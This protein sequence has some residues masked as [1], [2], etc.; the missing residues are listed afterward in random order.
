MPQAQTITIDGPSASGKSTVAQQLADRL[1][2]LYFDTGV[3]YRAVTYA[4]LE[5]LGSVADEEKVTTLTEKIAIDVNPA[6]IQDGR[7][8]DVLVDGKDVTWQIRAVNVEANVSQVSAYPGV[9]RELTLQQRRIGLRGS[10][11][12]VGR[13]IGTV[14]L[15]EAELKIYLDASVEIRARRRFEELRARGEDNRFEDILSAMKRRDKID[16]NRIVSPLRPAEDARIIN[17]DC[18]SV[19]EVCKLILSW[20]G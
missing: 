20:V 17:S 11:V 12:M 15:P 18:L 10:V 2:Y 9:R 8:Y 7:M 19:D 16:S 6:S 3:M 5:S 4:A 1:V 14:V 13:D